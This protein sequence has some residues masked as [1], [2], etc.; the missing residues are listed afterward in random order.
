[1]RHGGTSISGTSKLTGKKLLIATLVLILGIQ[2]L[3]LL[4]NPRG[5]APVVNPEPLLRTAVRGSVASALTAAVEQ[6]SGAPPN[7]YDYD[8]LPGVHMVYMYANGSDPRLAGPREM[9]GG[10]KGGT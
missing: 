6:H 1:M 10:P 3:V 4:H 9:F 2:L 5:E 7:K 8:P